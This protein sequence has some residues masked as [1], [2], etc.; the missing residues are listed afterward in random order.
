MPAAMFEDVEWIEE[1]CMEMDAMIR[2]DD[3]LR[4]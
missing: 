2:E 4:H 1:Y 3:G